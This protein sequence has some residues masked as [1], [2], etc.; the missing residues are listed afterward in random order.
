M[1]RFYTVTACLNIEK[2]SDIIEALEKYKRNGGNI[3][4]LIRELLRQHFF[5]NI[6][7]SDKAM[8]ELIKMKKQIDSAKELINKAIDI[9]NNIEGRV[10]DLE[11][12]I[13]E[14]EDKKEKDESIKRSNNEIKQSNNTIR[15][16]DKVV[17]DWLNEFLRR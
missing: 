13:S 3:S 2:D 16:D 6:E 4:E 5:I 11:N 17:E 14:I 9:I 1:A 10:K 12:K 7:V 8:V 15:T